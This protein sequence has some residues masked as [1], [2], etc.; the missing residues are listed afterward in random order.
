M[1]AHRV[2]ERLGGPPVLERTVESDLDLAEVVEGGLPVAAVES[3]IRSGTFSAGEIYALVLPRRTLTHRRQ[4]GQRLT[5]EES[6]RLARAVRLATYAEEAIGN[7]EKAARWLRTPNR[8]LVGKRP[9]D[10]LNSDLGTR[11]VEQVLGRVEYGLGP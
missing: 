10:L 11:M 4:K 2:A 5:A 6:D 9:L 1:T 7:V 8:A 3:V